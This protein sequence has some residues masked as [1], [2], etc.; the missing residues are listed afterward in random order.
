MQAAGNPGKR[1]CAG[2][3]TEQDY[4][5]RYMIRR[6]VTW[7]LLQS[8][9]D[10]LRVL[11]DENWKN[12]EYHIAAVGERTLRTVNGAIASSE[13]MVNLTNHYLESIDKL[14]TM[15]QTISTC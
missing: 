12:G 14:E 13:N 8:K 11:V 1:K 4:R 15:I 3:F 10:E 2:S 9:R 7:R 6:N 5:R